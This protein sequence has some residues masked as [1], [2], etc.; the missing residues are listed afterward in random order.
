MAPV[1]HNLGLS[2][3]IIQHDSAFVYDPDYVVDDPSLDHM[4]PVHRREAYSADITYGTNNEFGFDYLRDT[5]GDV[6]RRMRAAG[7]L[8]RHR[9]RGGLDPHRRGAHARS[10]SRAW[11]GSRRTCTRSLQKIVDR[12]K[13]GEDYE[14]DEKAHSVPLTEEGVAH[15]E[16][17]LGIRKPASLYDDDNIE[18]DHHANQALRA[19][20]LYRLD[21][22]YV[23]KDGGEIVIVDEFTGRLMFGRR[24]SDGLHQA[25]EAKEGVKVR[26]EDQTLATITFQNYFRLYHKLGGMTGTAATEEKE[27]RDIYNLDVVVIPTNRP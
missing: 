6:A 1:Y 5:H 2:V 15:L 25:I 14:V 23:I 10:S 21:V 17:I 3:G 27:F 7:T 22:E 19:K 18:L 4:R 20:E 12:L 11:G 16:D 8:V 24:Y 13:K 9:R 26:Q